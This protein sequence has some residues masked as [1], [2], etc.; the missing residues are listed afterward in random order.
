MANKR[1]VYCE[2]VE[3][4]KQIILQ[5]FFGR[6]RPSA[7]L[8]FETLGTGVAVAEFD[9]TGKIID[10][11]ENFL[12]I[13]G[14]ERDE[15][16]GGPHN[17]LVSDKNAASP[18]Y[19]RFWSDLRDGAYQSGEF[20]YV[21]KDGSKI[22]LQASY[23]PIL[24]PDGHPF[25]VVTY[26]SDITRTVE[27]RRMRDRVAGLMDGNL[28]KM[29]SA[30][31]S[32]NEKSMSATAA[33]SETAKRVNAAA[34]RAREFAAL[35]GDISRRSGESDSAVDR[36]VEEITL[37]D[38]T[39]QSLSKAA[40]NMNSII[41]LIQ[42]VANQINL[43]SLNATIESAR[44]GAAG[45]GFAVVGSEVK[46]LAN[47]VAVA[48]DQISEEIFGMQ[49]VSHDVVRRLQKVK[50]ATETVRGS[51]TD[52]AATIDSQ[53]AASSEI[54]K[55][56]ETASAAVAAIGEGLDEISRSVDAA[57]PY[58]TEGI[59]MYRNVATNAA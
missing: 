49:N 46:N 29:L 39:T 3:Q 19:A 16:V 55:D 7:K 20:P 1:H 2:F 5:S 23:N 27:A 33:S 31:E 24:D 9:L 37:A 40:E 44:A 51:V 14:Y 38:E 21:A 17:L 25:K 4:R 52:V 42:T 22:W 36:V 41:E 11:N 26:A 28:Q 48:T 56:M 18:E 58:S 53:S 6:S 13:V 15:L 30:V 8:A 32:A 54:M 35:V 59:K 57:N 43:L 10:A 12:A 34:A 50:E 47:Q 45:K